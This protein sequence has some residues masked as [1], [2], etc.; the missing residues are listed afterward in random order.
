MIKPS[1]PDYFEYFGRIYGILLYKEFVQYWD[2]IKAFEARADDLVIA[3]FSK[4]GKSPS[5]FKLVPI[6][7]RNDKTTLNGK[8]QAVYFFHTHSPY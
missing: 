2:D 4:S 3:T 1:K 7:P 6:L 8:Y 5:Y